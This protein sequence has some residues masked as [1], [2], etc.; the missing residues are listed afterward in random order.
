MSHHRVTVAMLTPSYLRLFHGRAPDSLRCVLT[1]GERPN[2]E[3]ARSYARKLEYWNLHGATEVCGTIC[4]LR[5]HPA[6]SGPLPSGRPFANTSVYLLDRNGREVAP[7]EVGE[8]HVVGAGVARGY[9]NQPELTAARFVETP[10]GRAYRSNDLGRWNEEGNLEAL[11]RA[12]DVIKV[13]GQAVSLGEIEQS[14][15]RHESVRCAAVL[16]HT[17]KLIAFVETDRQDLTLQHWHGFLARTLPAYMLPASVTALSRVPVNSYGKVDRQ[18]LVA[19]AA[20]NSEPATGTLPQGALEQKIAETWKEVLGVARV[21]R[22]DNFFALGGTSLLSIAVSQR[23][24]SLGHAVPARTILAAPT[25][26]ALAVKIAEEPEPGLATTGASSDKGAATSGQEDFWIAWKLGLPAPGAQI[27]R[28]LSVHGT[29]PEPER[30]QAAWTQVVSRHAALRTAFFANSD[31]KLC[32]R[33]ANLDELGSAVQISVDNCDSPDDVAASITARS[34]QPFDLSA[35]PLARAGLVRGNETLFWFTLHHSIADGLSARIVQEEMHALLL[36]RPLAP[37]VNGIAQASQAEQQYLASE[38]AERDRAYWKDKLD[39]VP[40]D[41]FDEFAID[42]RRPEGASGKSGARLTERLDAAAVAALTELAQAQHVGLHAL[43]LTLLAADLSR[44]DSR[45]N[46][47]IG[48]GIS[49]RPAGAERSVGHFVNLLPLI[50]TADPSLALAAQTRANQAALTETV[51]HGTCPASLLYREFRERHPDA[52]LPSRTSLFDIALTANPPRTCADPDT[53][54]SLT[55]WDSREKPTHPAAGLDLAFSYEPMAD[56]T[57]G[58]E[59]A[60]A[61]NP[62]VYRLSTAQALL[63][64]FAAWARWLAENTRCAGSSL[65]PLLPEE[66]QRLARWENG[67]VRTRAAKRVHQLVEILAAN[68]PHRPAVVTDAGV[69]TYAE[70]ERQANRIARALQERG[71]EREEP[72]AVLTECSADLPATVLGIWKAGAAYLPLALD[73]PPERLAFMASD[74]GAST[75]IV[76]DGHPVPAQLA[77]AVEMILGPEAW[78]HDS[79]PVELSG[80]PQDLAYIIYTSGSTGTPKGVLI[81][82]DGL[83]N[84]ALMTGE[85]CGLAADDRISLAATPGFDASLW[86]LGI[87]LLHG[88]AIVPVSRALRDDPW[89]LK[90]WYKRSGVTVAFHSPSYLRISKRTPFEG[91]RV[92]LTGGE[93]PNHED[94]GDYAGPL[95]FWNA[96]GPTE[97]SILVCAEQLSPAPDPS[98]PLPAG[99][100]LANTRISIRR[101]RGEPAPP[102]VVGEVWLG[103]AGLARGYLNNPDLTAQRFVQ[104]PEGRFYRSGDLGRW[105]DDGRL[106]LAG[107]IDHQ[108][109]LHGQRVELGEIERALS[110][111]AGI[112]DAVVLVEASAGDTKALRAFVHLRDGAPSPS[113][114]EWRDYLADRLP[115]YMVP[116]SV[117]RVD[118]IPLTSAGK[119]DRDALLRSPREPDDSVP[120]TA[121]RGEMETR[122]ASVWQDLLGCAVSLEDNFFALGGNSLLAVSMAHRLSTELALPVPARELFAAPTLAG[123]ARKLEALPRAEPSASAPVRSDLATQG[124]REFYTAEAAGLDTNTFTI[125]VVRVVEGKMP[126]LETWNAEWSQLVARHEALRTRFH[127]DAE[128]RLR[129]IVAPAIDQA[130]ETATQP[131]RAAARAYIRQRQSEPFVM[132]APPLW[133][134]GLVEVTDSGEHLFW[135]ALHHSVGDGGSVGILIDELCALLGGDDVPAPASDYNESAA[136]E[137]VYLAGAA[138][139]E[140]ARYWRDLL[141]RQPD[142]AFEEGPL[143]YARSS[144]A[145][146]GTHRFE[147]RL[148]VATVDSLRT[149]ARQHETSLHAVMLTL[150]A[151]EAR[152]RMR[153]SDLVIGTTASVRETA[154]DE[155]VVG[156]YVNML[157]APCHLTRE[158]SFSDALRQNG[159]SL[160]AGLQHARYPLANMYRDFW[161]ERPQQRDPARYPLFDLAVTENPAGKTAP[162]STRLVRAQPDAYE[163]TGASPGQDMVL[164]HEA[165]PDG[166]LLLQWHVNAAVYSRETAAA[167]F[168]SLSGWAAWL[169]GEAGRAREAMPFLLPREAALLE[170]REQG[171]KT[172]RPALHFHELFEQILDAPDAGQAERPAVITETGA[173]TYAALERE[174]NVIA[175]SLLLRGAGPGAVAAVLTG[176]SGSLPAAVLGI[177]KTGATYLPLAADL[178][179]DRLVFMAHDAGA[180]QLIVLDGLA[181]PPELEQHLP[182]PLRPDEIDAQFRRTHRHRPPP[183]VDDKDAAYIIYTSGSTGRPKGT[184]IGHRAYVNTVLGAGEAIGLTC[185]DRSLMFSSPS[186]DVSLSDMGLPLAF[187]AAICPV[188]YDVLS[189]PNRF[190]AFLNALNVTV[191][192]ITPTYLRLFNGA[193]LPSLRVL[194]TGGEAPFP[195]DIETYASRHQYFNAYGPTENTITSTIGRLHPG[196]DGIASAGRPLPNTSVHVCDSEG[197][198]L[199]PGMAGELWLGAASLARCY[200]GRT[201]L[202]AAAFRQTARGRLYRTGDLGRWRANGDIEILGRTDDQVKLNGIRIELGEIEHALES[203]PAIGQAVAVIDGDKTNHRLWAFVRPLPGKDA[204]AEETWRDYLASR[205]PAYMIPANVIAIAEIP[206]SNSGKVDKAALKS[207]ITGRARAHDDLLPAGGLESEIAVLWAE[208]LRC[209]PVHAADNFFAFGGHSLLAIAVAHRLEEKLGYA[210][211]ARELFA[212]PTLREFARRV[213]ELKKAAA[214]EAVSSDRATEGQREFWVAERAGL[215]TRGFNI[216]LVVTAA[217]AIPADDEWRRAWATLVSRHDALR[218]AFYEDQDGVL[219]RSVQPQIHA[220]F[221]IMSQPDLAAALAQVRIRQSEPFVMEKAPLW[222]AGLMRVAEDQPVFWLALHHSV[223]DGF[224]L[225]ILI[226]ELSTLLRGG[227]LAATAG[228]FDR[229]AGQEESYLTGSAS[230]DDAQYWRTSWAN[231][232]TAWLTHPRHSMNG[233]STSRAPWAARLGTRGCNCVFRLRLDPGTAAGLRDLGASNG[234]SLHALMLTMLAREVWRRTRRP[235]SSLEPPHPP[236]IRPSKQALSA[237]T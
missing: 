10:Y 11:G 148:D 195:A 138:C 85:A 6:S 76:L 163:R 120:K 46:L 110:S 166:G 187:G 96:Y 146:P 126:A 142:S 123:F 80:T 234:A 143:D 223:A 128:G 34:C 189:S 116:A 179:P 97:T 140:D 53:G 49:V 100:P 70:L 167:W 55:P 20:S 231:W 14:L 134:A 16:Q 204:P 79:E 147:A 22:E 73:Q 224:S 212:G 129:R 158:A 41:A 83:I 101:T 27:T 112:D 69:Q 74:A 161:S 78:E 174:A 150:L 192:D 54:F 205:L 124:Q 68:Q 218:T 178:P 214:P 7:G 118:A 52:R 175:H 17:G 191:A 200:V 72:V 206:L 168:E 90:E 93:A 42:H 207:M 114:A 23:L 37:A 229:S 177:W 99:R 159:R 107:R 18:A 176:R 165:L 81:Q 136:R 111:H 219:R 184:L 38:L 235:N 208:V 88:M 60:L 172:P 71:V 19:L 26:A 25:V 48:S 228:H 5:V 188:P 170:T 44:R 201:D 135:L 181:V 199:P 21:M 30:W 77:G 63:S 2:A 91:L 115:A 230:R 117:T 9:L 15:T 57:G 94:A 75:L 194:V 29:V 104:T 113:Q 226:D 43:L 64:S 108:V 121:P 233:L 92:L 122:V 130:L 236:A 66:E 141:A 51:E 211:P 151:V 139:T 58:L 221:E 39:A 47:V 56:E 105:T 62:D 131:D 210:V 28:V 86:E 196:Q 45:S 13:S 216:P 209:G 157:P 215:D 237:I 8:I 169:A 173:T 193:E 89:A 84:A 36:W 232:V 1:A 182:V 82:H 153:R 160:A 156:Y 225:G 98:R 162:A 145:N 40:R 102:G 133:R 59:L 180:T 164:I 171:A 109:K 127:E 50:L 152:R 155:Q 144:G 183:V 106:E 12:D 186:F 227:T 65:P 198:P 137:E 203:H 119:V 32:W 217:G 202:T 61:W 154:A 87:G 33:T 35:P 222:R 132:G 220:N 3:D 67:P 125:P 95:D 197:N 190:R 4:M 103:G 31:D 213:E 185:D 24:Q 149:L